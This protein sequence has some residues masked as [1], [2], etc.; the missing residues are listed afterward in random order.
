MVVVSGSKTACKLYKPTRLLILLINEV[1]LRLSGGNKMKR[2][3][4]GGYGAPTAR[5]FESVI[6]LVLILILGVFIAGK[7]GLLDLSS[8]PVVGSLFPR[9]YIKVVVVGSESPY[10]KNLMTSEDYRIAGINY[11]GPI[12]QQAVVPG[13]LNSFDIIILQ[14]STVCDRPARKVIADRVKGG[15]KLIVVGDA[16][17]RVTDDQN[18]VGWDVGIGSL[19]DVVPVTY[20]GVLFHEPTGQSTVSVPGGKFKIVAPDHPI[21][22]G[23]KNF[24]FTGVVTR[25]L[26]SVNSNALAYLDTYYNR[27][28][29]PATFAIVESQGMLTGKT[30]YFSFDPGTTSRNMLLNALLYLKGAKG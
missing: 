1:C 23:I 14:G 18:A 5:S 21:F 22:N 16:C 8:I 9:P 11:V 27:V 13:V 29:A 10:L 20:G 12:Q 19:G 17:T 6:P 7:F 15:G 4:Y 28:T 30:L 2:G 24:A 26:P 25:A 3:Q